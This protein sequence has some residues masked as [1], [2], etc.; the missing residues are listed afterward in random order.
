VVARTPDKR[1]ENAG[2]VCRPGRA[3]RTALTRLARSARV[4]CRGTRQPYQELMLNAQGMP[5]RCTTRLSLALL[6]CPLAFLAG[7]A[8]DNQKTALSASPRVELP[9][10]SGYY[11][12]ATAHPRRA[13]RKPVRDQQAYA[14]QE[15]AK[16]AETLLAQSQDWDSDARLV[17]LNDTQRSTRHAVVDSFR[18]SLEGLK[19]AAEKSDIAALHAQYARAT[20]SYR[21]I[22]SLVAP[23]E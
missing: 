7:C 14:L 6:L 21:Q 19:A 13:V 3:A 8:A 18:T 5:M 9:G 15:L 17:S 20:A 11:A 12:Q 23:A 10:I 2:L 4:K 16:S 22:N 1:A